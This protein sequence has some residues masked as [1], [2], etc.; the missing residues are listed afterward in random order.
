[1]TKEEIIQK[2]LNRFCHTE[3]YHL[4]KMKGQSLEAIAEHFYEIGGKQ[5]MVLP[6]DVKFERLSLEGNVQIAKG[7]VMKDFDDNLYIKNGRYLFDKTISK[8]PNKLFPN[9]KFAD[10]PIEIELIIREV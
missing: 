10:S 4:A 7:F 1:M 5:E 2:E 8:I 6:D 9:F 3:E